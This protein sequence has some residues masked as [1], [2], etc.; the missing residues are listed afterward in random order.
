[1]IIVIADDLTGAG[2]IGGIGLDY[3]ISV[4]VQ[5]GFCSKTD[6]QLL[7]IDTDTRS[8]S[9]QRAGHKIRRMAQCLNTAG[10]PIEWVYKKTDSVLRGPIATE[11]EALQ[12]VMHA[13]RVLLVPANPSKGRIIRNG[14]Y[15][16]DGKPLCET[17]FL[18]DPEYPAVTSNV[19]QLPALACGR[20]QI[21]LLDSS[22]KLG[23][24][25][26]MIGQAETADD[27]MRWAEKIDGQTLAAGA[28]E[29]FEAMLRNKGLSRKPAADEK[30]YR[31][32]DSVLF[33]CGSSSDSSRQ[34]I[35][36]AHLQGA[37]VSRMPDEL[38]R[39]D[40]S[41]D[42]Y[43]Q[44]WCNE[45]T[46]CFGI[47]RSVIM[48]IDRPLV[49]NAE[50]AGR[51]S[52]IMAKTVSAVLRQIPLKE[53]FIEGGATAFRIADYL[54]WNRFKPC[55]HLGPGAVRMKVLESDNICLT[56]KPGSY[57]WPEKIRNVFLKGVTGAD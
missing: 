49:G 41:A 17:D 14:N 46:A 37:R 56:V 20:G 21:H 18:N 35:K 19:L 53:I 2:E 44:Q 12:D 16:I 9:P 8:L 30:E 4:E 52:S 26:I 39:S 27:L 33:V 28:G 11:L 55:D 42:K 15:L 5:R 43:L 45:I 3:G 6:V 34:D 38:F 32:A 48:A 51:L 13:A 31:L 40:D 1:M 25:G 23:S 57:P 10:I 29:F 7:V 36:T 54:G 50:F 22:Q 24:E 47:S